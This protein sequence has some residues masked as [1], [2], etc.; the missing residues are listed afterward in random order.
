MGQYYKENVSVKLEDVYLESDKQTPIIF[1]LSK[2]ADP[3]AD[4][5]KLGEEKQFLMY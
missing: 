5:K 2:G 3:T 4:I 1:I